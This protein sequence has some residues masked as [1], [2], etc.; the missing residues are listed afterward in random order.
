MTVRT[1][2]LRSFAHLVGIG[3]QPAPAAA[4]AEEEDDDRKKRDD[5]TDDEHA[6]RL[7]KMDEDEKEQK[8][9]EAKAAAK[10]RA[11]AEGEGDDE[12]DEEDEKDEDAK[13]VRMRERGRC[14]AIFADPAAA[15]NPALAAHLAFNTNQNRSEAI[16]SLR[17]SV[18]ADPAPA[19]KRSRLDR[20]MSRVP[21]PDVPTGAPAAPGAGTAK[22]LAAGML[23]L[24]G[25]A[26]K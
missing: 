6:A 11:K 16:G 17:A 13:A 25:M 23:A 3:R 4:R 7:A 1:T 5:E 9:K 24:A 18:P 2:A 19:P 26:P 12:S 14:A 8:E 10:R 22:G 21:V 15:K 20:D